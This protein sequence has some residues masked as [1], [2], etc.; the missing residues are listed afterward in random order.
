M[1]TVENDTTRK[2]FPSPSPGTAGLYI[3][4]NTHL[5]AALK[6]DIF[7]DGELVAETVA[8]TYFYF[9]VQGGKRKLSTE[10]EFSPNDLIIDVEKGNNYFVRQSMR[11]GIFVGGAKLVLVPEEEGKKGVLECKLGNNFNANVM[12]NTEGIETPV[13]ASQSKPGGEKSALDYYGQAE[14]EINTETYDKNLWAKALVETEGDQ[15]KRK[16]RYIELRA[17]QL[18][19]AKVASVSDTSLYQQATPINTSTQIDISGTYVSDITSDKT[20]AFRK[21]KDRDLRIFFTQT[22]D[23]ITG[24]ND[25]AD[26][27]IVGTRKGDT[28]K[29]FMLANEINGFQEA[30]GVWNIN[31][32][33]TRI[34]GK[35]EI[36]GAGAVGKWNLTKVE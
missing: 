22:G 7:I 24:V 25:S 32:D 1:A 31:T 3:Y 8:M 10:S 20:W 15:T 5:G 12:V 11:L 33:G 19:F 26:L 28:I 21:K 2:S 30:K 23:N 9:E 29:F 35:W 18:Y 36:P 6:K 34:E 14:E 17:N 4:R 16:A 13:L 27:K